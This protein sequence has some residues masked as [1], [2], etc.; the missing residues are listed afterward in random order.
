ML[1]F[2]TRLEALLV[3]SGDWGTVTEGVTLCQA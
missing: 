3:H 2:I 1:A